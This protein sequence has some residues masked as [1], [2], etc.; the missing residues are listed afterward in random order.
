MELQSEFRTNNV[1]NVMGLLGG[2]L[3]GALAGSVAMLLF[4]PQ[5]GQKTRE[6]IKQKSIELRNLTT[7]TV[8]DAMAQTRQKAN[9]IKGIVQDQV[10]T[11]HKNGEEVM[12]VIES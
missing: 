2:L 4:A 10:K 1:N 5:S 11:L 9:Q 6:Q 3:V 7:D 12:D 8:E